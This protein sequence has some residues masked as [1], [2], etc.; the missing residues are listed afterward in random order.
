MQRR[1][2]HRRDGGD[3]RWPG[4]LRRRRH[5]RQFQGAHGRRT[6]HGR[7]ANAAA[8]QLDRPRAFLQA[9]DRR[10]QRRKRGRGRDDDPADG[11][12]RRLR[13]CQVR[14]GVCEDGRHAGTRQLALP[15]A[16]H[17][18]RQGQRNVPQRT[19]LFRPRSVRDGLGGPPRARRQAARRSHHAGPGN[20][21]QPLAPL[22]LGEG[23]AHRQR[24]KRTSPK[25]S[26][27]KAKF[28]RK[29]TPPPN[30]RKP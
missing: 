13:R 26:S 29:P 6:E 16:A 27:A 30:T 11:R 21:R 14:H 7:S 28:W 17:G 3:G 4:L 20:G 2:R 8:W 15:R 25:C 12:D 1:R 18:L 22:A 9:L 10:R 5:P 24:R 19:A 23:T